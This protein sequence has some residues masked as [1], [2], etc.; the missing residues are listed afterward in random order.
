MHR[1]QLCANPQCVYLV[2]FPDRY[3][4]D[5]ATPA[6]KAPATTPEAR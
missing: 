4:P 2:R 3:C 6:T 5:H 1:P